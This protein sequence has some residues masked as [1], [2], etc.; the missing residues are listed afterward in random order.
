MTIE[1]A[2]PPFRKYKGHASNGPMCAGEITNEQQRKI[3]EVE[4]RTKNVEYEQQ[5]NALT[6]KALAMAD[7]HATCNDHHQQLY[8]SAM[9]FLAREAGIRG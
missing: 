6:D 5:I 9:N 2:P 4:S 8:H 1:W 3:K 7:K